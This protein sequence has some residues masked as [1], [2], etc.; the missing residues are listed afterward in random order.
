M[1]CPQI[2]ELPPPPAGKTGWPWTEA[3]PR[4]ADR[5]PDGSAWP[6]ISIVT[7]T[8]NHVRYIEQTIRT[9][10]LQGYPDLE[11]LV[12]DGG[13][14]DGTVDVIR[15]YEPWIA[16][17]VSEPDR[18]QSHAI[19]KG[20]AA[21]TGRWA[22]WLCSDDLFLPGALS[23][24]ARYAAAHPKARWLTGSAEYV[25]EETGERNRYAATYRSADRMMDFWLYGSPGHTIPQQAVF[26]DMDLWRQAGGLNEQWDLAMDYDL[27]LR[28]AERGAQ[29]HPLDAVLAVSVLHAD[30]KSLARKRE[31]VREIMRIAYAAARRR[32]RPTTTA[33][34]LRLLGWSIRRHWGILR[35]HR[36]RC[37]WG[38]VARQLLR[39]PSLAV[40]VWSER[41]RM[42]MLRHM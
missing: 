34:T 15:K 1:R 32:R 5:A 23:T 42:G 18:G 40:R 9:V 28:F 41:G 25:Y 14:T 22:T 8:F 3:S 35:E 2:D 39:I 29:L 12:I 21:A 13:S 20:L 6:R 31:Q 19:N 37:W 26:W 7:P 27:W 11:Y 33:L 4:L 24:V 38:G 10:L 16:R 17:W 30:C 36:R